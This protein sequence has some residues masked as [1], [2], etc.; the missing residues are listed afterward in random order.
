MEHPVELLLSDEYV[1]F[2]KKVTDLHVKKKSLKDAFKV[3]IEELQKQLKD[4]CK[5]VDDEAKVLAQEWE[6]WKE[7][8][9]KSKTMPQ[10]IHKGT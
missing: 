9:T 1:E 10:F 7:G 2:S 8:Q 5:S 6:L 3:K 4:A